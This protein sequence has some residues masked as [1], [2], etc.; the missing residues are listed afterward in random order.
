MSSAC[1][2]ENQDD[3]GGDSDDSEDY[4]D[5]NEV[6]QNIYL[7]ICDEEGREFAGVTTFHGMIRI[8]TSRTWTSLI[9]WV[10]VVSTCLVFFMIFSGNILSNYAN[11]NTFMRRH[12]DTNNVDNVYLS[13]CGSLEL[14]TQHIY[15]IPRISSVHTKGDCLRIEARTLNSR[16]SIV[17]QQDITP[18]SELS[19]STSSPNIRK[20]N[21][22]RQISRLNTTNA[23]CVSDFSELSW[24]RHGRLLLEDLRVYSLQAC[25]QM[26]VI[27]WLLRQ[28]GCVPSKILD[29]H[30]VPVCPDDDFRLNHAL[31]RDFPCYPPCSALEWQITSSYLRTSRGLKISLEFSKKMEILVEV[32]K[33]GITDVLSSVGGGTSLFLGCS[34]VTLMETF[35]FLLK[36]VLQSITKES[37]AGPGVAEETKIEDTISTHNFSNTLH[38][39]PP[40]PEN[41]GSRTDVNDEDVI[42]LTSMHASP[43]KSIHCARLLQSPQDV[44]NDT[45]I[46]RHRIRPPSLSEL[47]FSNTFNEMDA[48]NIANPKRLKNLPLSQRLTFDG[49]MERPRL[50]RQSAIDIPDDKL[51]QYLED[52]SGKHSAC[53]DSDRKHPARIKYR[54]ISSV[55][56]RGSASSSRANVHIVEHARRRSQM[57]N[58]FMTMNDF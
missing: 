52:I 40:I 57:Y 48:R 11:R 12:T 34:C 38:S 8:F 37:Y 14:T 4:D 6:I 24:I 17:F 42:G 21:S 27:E 15:A 36:L 51:D 20:S 56:S 2:A 9:F 58:K 28:Q 30:R 7:H 41:V 47:K 13:I 22:S 50:K 31:Q 25:E 53:D 18:T 3:A 43:L 49:K 55:N 29:Q 46:Q 33:M 35:V 19:K 16:L 26:Q 45:P 44:E 32:Q 1:S 5:D 39:D 10:L 23:P 54:R